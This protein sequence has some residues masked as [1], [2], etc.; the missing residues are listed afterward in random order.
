MAYSTRKLLS[1]SALL[2]ALPIGAACYPNTAQAPLETTPEVGQ[3]PTTTDST[4]PATT[5]TGTETI[6]EVAANDSSL[7]TFNQAVEAAG[8]SEALSEPGPYTVFAPSDQAFEA[9]PPEALQQL[10]LPENRDQLRQLLSYHVVPEALPADQLQSG[11]VDT[12]A[13]AP[14]TVDVDSNIQDV[15]INNAVVTQPNLQASNGIVHVVDQVILPPT[16]N[17]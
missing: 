6:A 12:L 9:L 3:A 17:L 7:S 16:S 5:A 4:N 10:L 2:L 15:S 14:L 11:E 13:G 1:L 8:L